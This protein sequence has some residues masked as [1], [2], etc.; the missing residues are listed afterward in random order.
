MGNENIEI[1]QLDRL[2]KAMAEQLASLCRRSY[3]V[4]EKLLGSRIPDAAITGAVVL[5]AFAAETFL[6]AFDRDNAPGSAPRGLLSYFVSPGVIE[7]TRLVVDPGHF[8][9]GIGTALHKKLQELCKP[10]CRFYLTTGCKNLPALAF[11]QG[12]GYHI[13]GEKQSPDGVCLTELE[14]L[15]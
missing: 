13:A 14:M 1:H 4:E 5:E 12:L 10:P 8:R 6:I 3:A 7:I 15:F 11:Y 9:R 2:P